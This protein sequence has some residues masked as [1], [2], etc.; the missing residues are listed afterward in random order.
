MKAILVRQFGGPEA[1]RYEEVERP[2]PKR[3][4]VLVKVR[5]VSLNRLDIWVRGGL[6][7]YGTTLPH[8]LG[9][10]FSGEVGEVSPDVKDFAFGDR[11]VVDPALRCLHCDY[12]L[13]GRNNLCRSFGIIG[14]T[15]WGG[16]AEYAKV[17][18]ENLIALPDSV[19][20]E[21]GAAFPLTYQTAWHMLVDRGKMEAGHSVLIIAAG[22]GVGVAALQTAKLHGAKVI[23][24]AGGKEKLRR[25]AGLG[26]DFLIDH[27]TQDIQKTVMDITGGAGVDI[28]FEHVG[29]ATFSHSLGSLKKD[30]RLVICGATTGPDVALN[31]RYLFSKQ[32]AILGSIMG[33]RQEFQKVAGLVAEGKLKPV[34]DEI[35]PLEEAA[36][37]H[38]KMEKSLH[39]GKIIL[40]P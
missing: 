17:K 25:L 15:I 21:E 3:G 24:T 8:V 11:V 16:Y 18:S 39:F 28:A 14:A 23:A 27:K 30:G 26:A 4:E 13:S 19:S 33:T 29:P 5:A 10:D 22:S 12:C 38:I 40:R 2:S 35:F 9:C 32:I 1:L 7:A 37:A 36:R 31:L 6:T 34:I 20:F